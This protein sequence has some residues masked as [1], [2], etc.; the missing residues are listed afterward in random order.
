MVME[1][2][3]CEYAMSMTQTQTFERVLVL[4]KAL[5]PALEP[6]Q[7]KVFVKSFCSMDG[8]FAELIDLL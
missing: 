8:R 6:T 2:K 3:C 1:A 4:L 5:L 7:R